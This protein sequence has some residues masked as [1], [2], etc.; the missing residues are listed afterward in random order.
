MSQWKH[1]KKSFIAKMRI[2]LGVCSFIL[3]AVC[4]EIF[5]CKDTLFALSKDILFAGAKI[6]LGGCVDILFAV[7]GFIFFAEWAGIVF[8]VTIQNL[9]CL[10]CILFF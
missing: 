2:F 3:F 10:A 5:F 8:D 7:C 6:F 4:K 1:G 9:F